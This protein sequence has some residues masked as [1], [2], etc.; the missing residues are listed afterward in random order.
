MNITMTT[1]RRLYSC[2]IIITRVHHQQQ[3]HMQRPAHSTLS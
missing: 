2:S 3:Q 1:Y